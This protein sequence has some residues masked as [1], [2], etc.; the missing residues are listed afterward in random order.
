[1][2]RFIYRNI[3]W[4]CGRLTY[5]AR[6]CYDAGYITEDEA[7]KYIDKSYQLASETFRDWK[8]FAKSYVIGRA[9]WGGK[10]SSNSVIIDVSDYLVNNE[11]SPWKS[12]LLRG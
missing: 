8:D 11:K 6:M 5:V 9:M 2:R 4:D 1:M 3:G 10:T 12:I 7:R